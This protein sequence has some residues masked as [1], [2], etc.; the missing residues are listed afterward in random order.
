[1]NQP[2]WNSG[3][4][5]G[6]DSGDQEQ[7]DTTVDA[8]LRDELGLTDDPVRN[9]SVL[10]GATEY[11]EKVNRALVPIHQN[12]TLQNP[13]RKVLPTEPSTWLY[14]IRNWLS[15]TGDRSSFGNGFAATLGGVTVVGLLGVLAWVYQSGGDL[16]SGLGTN[17]TL[18]P[19][20]VLRGEDD[21]N[22][23]KVG[24]PETEADAFAKSLRAT[25]CGAAVRNTGRA[26]YVDIDV[27]MSTCVGG[28]AVLKSRDLRVE[29]TG[30]G[31]VR[32]VPL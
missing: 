7:R 17:R 31:T 24:N 20:Q 16:D 2:P 18:E 13:T 32:F 15:L 11:L 4:V 19:A 10:D 8:A 21:G 23:R 1:M 5:A 22:V 3:E 30:R 29:A 9:R 12:N 25:G 26:V 14:T 27:S 28:T 6:A